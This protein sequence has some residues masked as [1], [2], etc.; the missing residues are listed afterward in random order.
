M[1][2]FKFPFISNGNIKFIKYCRKNSV[3]MYLNDIIIH[4]IEDCN[5]AVHD[6]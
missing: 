6:S 4:F 3:K 5:L 1:L 2:L